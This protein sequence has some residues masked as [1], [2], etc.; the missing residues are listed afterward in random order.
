MYRFPYIAGVAR[1]RPDIGTSRERRRRRQGED[2]VSE[3]ARWL[4]IAPGRVRITMGYNTVFRD[5]V[6]GQIERRRRVAADLRGR[7]DAEQ[8]LLE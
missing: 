6:D 2:R 3:T 1:H 4:G 7:Y 5:E 8:A